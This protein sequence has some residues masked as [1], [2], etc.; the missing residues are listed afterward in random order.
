VFSRGAL[1]SYEHA[2]V[3]I[4]RLTLNL[5]YTIAN[6]AIQQRDRNVAEVAMYLSSLE[7]S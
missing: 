7:V 6:S 4:L 3:V 2:K 5:S 1:V